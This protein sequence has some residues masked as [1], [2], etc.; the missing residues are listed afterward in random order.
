MLF[1]LIPISLGLLFLY[2]IGYHKKNV[3]GHTYQ[4]LKAVFLFL[5]FSTTSLA[6]ITRNIAGLKYI[7]ILWI[8][9]KAHRAHY[10][11]ML[12]K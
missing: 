2:K 7:D 10:M 8:V 12:I 5:I 6:L 9:T 3:F 1:I 4:R 11:R